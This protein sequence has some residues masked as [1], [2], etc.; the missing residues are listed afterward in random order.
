[1]EQIIANPTQCGG[2]IRCVGCWYRYDGNAIHA[3]F[4]TIDRDVK[5]WHS[6]KKHMD[7]N[8][9]CHAIESLA[10]AIIIIISHHH[11]HHE[12]II[13]CCAH[14]KRFITTGRASAFCVRTFRA[15]TIQ[16]S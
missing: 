1:M 8:Q 12:R 13:N 5:L 15:A 11:Y 16:P 3:L 9:L 6:R 10:I 4:L 14:V 2:E 7:F